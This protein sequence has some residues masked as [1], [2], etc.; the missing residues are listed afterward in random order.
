MA[1]NKEFF[2]YRGYSIPVKLVNLTGGGSDTWDEIAN[3]HMAMYQRHTPISPDFHILEV[4][5]GVGRDAMLL[6]DRLSEKDG[7]YIGV[8]IIQPSIEWCQE[9]ITPKHPNFTFKYLDIESQIHNPHG[10]RKTTDM[11]LPA[12]SGWA[13]LIILQSVFTHMFYD[14][15]VHYMQEF[16]RIL[17]PGGR[18]VASFFILNDEALKLI[19]KNKP[20]LSFQHE[21]G[22]G[23]FVNDAD[24]PEG[25][26]SYTPEKFEELLKDGG[27]ELAKPIQ[28]GVWCG[29]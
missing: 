26:V 29:R 14:D 12:K 10:K 23:C 7:K 11:E 24:Y 6:T 2:E 5:C 13:D 28:F 17:K 3:Y 25:A 16:R 22:P 20:Q 27:L 9:N 21:Y 4:G 18:V 19:K 1:K 15:I 8:D